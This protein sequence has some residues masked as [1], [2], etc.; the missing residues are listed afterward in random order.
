MHFGA[1]L[2]KFDVDRITLNLTSS[3]ICKNLKDAL[4]NCKTFPP[5]GHK[6][7]YTR[8]CDR[9]A[10][11]KIAKSVTSE[12]VHLLP[13]GFPTKPANIPIGSLMFKTARCVKHTQDNSVGAI[14][15]LRLS[16]QCRAISAFEHPPLT[17]GDDADDAR[18]KR[19]LFGSR[20]R[21]RRLR[22]STFE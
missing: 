5:L 11:C 7:K 14:T 4:R 8:L 16:R 1:N 19:S 10:K 15:I 9:L 22:D 13:F 2:M 20:C 18:S 6:S 12:S 21:R 17:A 3:D